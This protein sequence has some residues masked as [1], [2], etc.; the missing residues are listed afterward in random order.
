MPPEEEIS[1]LNFLK[2]ALNDKMMIILLVLGAVALALGVA[3]AIAAE[4]SFLLGTIAMAGAAV[5]ILPEIAA[6]RVDDASKLADTIAAHLVVGVEEKQNLLEIISPL[7]RLVRIASLLET[8]VDKL[9]VDRG[10]Q[11]RVKKQMEKAQKEYYL[12]EQMRA[13]Q[14]ELGDRDEF[15]NEIQEIE[16]QFEAKD[17]PDAARERADKELKKLKMMS[18]MSAEATVVRNYVDWML[19]LP[20]FEYK[21]ENK[22]IVEAERLDQRLARRDIPGQ[23]HDARLIPAQA[24][25]LLRTEHAV[26]VLASDLG[27]LELES[28]GKCHANCGERVVSSFFDDRGATDDL[29]HFLAVEDF[30]QRQT[31]RIGMTTHRLHLADDHVLESGGHGGDLLDGCP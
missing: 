16:E 11:S 6:V 19:G 5:L 2:E 22:D 30:A 4:F 8:E 21:E 10:I 20:W 18:P 14:K 1:Y 9:Q 7:E 12:N 13:I 29:Y 17:M 24:E 26:G 27:S 31:I 15:K 28:P 3:P 25:L 23:E